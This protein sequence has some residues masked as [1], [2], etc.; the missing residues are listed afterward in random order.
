MSS[1]LCWECITLVSWFRYH[2]EIN[3]LKWRIFIQAGKIGSGENTKSLLF[4]LDLK[5]TLRTCFESKKFWSSSCPEL[6]YQ[7]RRYSVCQI[8]QNIVSK[9]RPATKVIYTKYSKHWPYT[10][11]YTFDCV[12]SKINNSWFNPW[13]SFYFSSLYPAPYIKWYMC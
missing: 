12:C 5:Y 11:A 13:F 8:C 7:V 4:L 6:R 10:V 2:P 3:N 1:S 9:S